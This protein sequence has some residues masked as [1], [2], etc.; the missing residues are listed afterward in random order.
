MH[1]VVDSYLFGGFGVV[2]SNNLCVW[3]LL[4]IL[5]YSCRILLTRYTSDKSLEDILKF[6]VIIYTGSSN[7]LCTL[8]HYAAVYAA[9]NPLSSSVKCVKDV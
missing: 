9:V 5:P 7:F 1:P 8:V 3:E 4:K 6:C 2:L